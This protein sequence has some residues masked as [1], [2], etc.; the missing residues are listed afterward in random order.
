MRVR[1][2]RTE[3]LAFLRPFPTST[4][5]LP[6]PDYNLV[7]PSQM[8][9]DTAEPFSSHASIFSSQAEPIPRKDVE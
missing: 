7:R 2:L 6:N 3:Q 1:F 5:S 9:R 8:F 4:P